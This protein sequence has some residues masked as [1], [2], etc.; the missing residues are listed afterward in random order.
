MPEQTIPGDPF[1]R[2]ILWTC[3][4]CEGTSSSHEWEIAWSQ[5]RARRKRE[6]DYTEDEYGKDFGLDQRMVCPRCRYVHS[7]DECSYVDE[8]EGTAVT[9][10][11]LVT[12][13]ADY[14]ITTR[15]AQPRR[16]LPGEVISRAMMEGAQTRREQDS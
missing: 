11:R 4:E 3:S 7:D 8:H 1:L 16:V 5:E 6:G 10:D 15:T 2:V 13:L 12:V 14:A 9:I